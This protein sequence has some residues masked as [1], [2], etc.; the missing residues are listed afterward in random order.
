MCTGAEIIFVHELL[1]LIQCFVLRV[2]R[3]LVH[4]GRFPLRLPLKKSVSASHHAMNR[5]LSSSA[6]VLRKLGSCRDGV[7]EGEHARGDCTSCRVIVLLLAD[8]N[9]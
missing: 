5:G 4:N 3:L 9:G 6:M 8:V 2:E 7:S 1:L